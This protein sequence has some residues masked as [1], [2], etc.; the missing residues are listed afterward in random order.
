MVYKI[1]AIYDT[2][3]E[4]GGPVFCAVNDGVAMRQFRQLVQGTENRNDFE[5]YYLADYDSKCVEIS[6]TIKSQ[7]PVQEVTAEVKK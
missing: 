6:E 4:E 5:L 1:Y 2:V 7:V 3:A